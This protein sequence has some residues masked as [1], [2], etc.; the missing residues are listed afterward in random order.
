MPS[1]PTSSSIDILCNIQSIH[2]VAVVVA[3]RLLVFPGYFHPQQMPNVVKSDRD[4]GTFGY[5]VDSPTTPTAKSKQKWMEEMSMTGFG[6]RLSQQHR[7]HVGADVV[8]VSS[9]KQSQSLLLVGSF[10][11]ATIC[12]IATKR[13][14]AHSI[15]HSFSAV[16][17]GS[18]K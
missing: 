5:P 3:S 18:K 11:R 12:S 1:M 14:Q 17:F 2:D 16:L 7:H 9:H 8:V 13:N 15:I 4:F 10:L 6:M